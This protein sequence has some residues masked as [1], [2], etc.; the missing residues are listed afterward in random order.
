M[1]TLM[2]IYCNLS[3]W[4]KKKKKN[5]DSKNILV[6]SKA[7]LMTMVL[8]FETS[9]ADTQTCGLSLLIIFLPL[10]II[11]FTRQADI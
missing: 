11:Y 4:I 1:R 7:M 9:I 5:Q 6:F 10:K 8:G 2:N 3:F